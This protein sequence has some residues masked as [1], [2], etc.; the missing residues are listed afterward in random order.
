MALSRDFYPERIFGPA[1]AL[2][3]AALYAEGL[4]GVIFDIDNTLVPQDMPADEGIPA[5]FEQ[6]KAAGFTVCIVSNN[7]EPR[8]KQFAD[9]AGVP[10]V[11]HAQKPSAKGFMEAMALLGTA[12]GETVCIGDQIFTD[13]LGANRAGIR[14]ILTEPVD[15]AS[16]T[17]FIRLKRV[18]EKPFCKIK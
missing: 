5:F 7:E 16:D 11:F 13:I 3:Y 15:L 9:S 10:Y 6:V 12:K 4:R 2:D 17:F 14:T 8:V 18:F 1:R